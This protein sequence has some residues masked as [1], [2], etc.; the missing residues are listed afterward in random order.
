MIKAVQ[1]IGVICAI[2]IAFLYG[3]NQSPEQKQVDGLLAYQHY[4]EASENLFA[5]CDCKA[6]SEKVKDYELA[7]LQL[8][9]VWSSQVME[10]PEIV[11]QRDKLSDVIRATMD[12]NPEVVEDILESLKIY[13]EDPSIINNWA[14]S[15]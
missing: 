14:Y 7:K 2:L 12:H 11:D 4:Y 13:F 5:Y 1:I 3:K 10:W 6:D 9:Q 8:D 15:Y